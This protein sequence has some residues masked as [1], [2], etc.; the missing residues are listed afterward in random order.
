[1]ALARRILLALNP[2]RRRTRWPL[3]AAIALAITTLVLFPRLDLL[4]RDLQHWSR[5]DALIE[6]DAPGLAALE[7]RV[8]Q[9]LGVALPT[10]SP[11]DP[12]R[13]APAPTPQLNGPEVLRITQAVVEEAIPYAW[14]WDTWW[15]AD[16]VPR[17]HET[18]KAGREDCDGRAVVAASLLKRM[19]Y[20]A[21]LMSDMGHVWVWTP[22]GQTMNP[23]PLAG[24]AVFVVQD[25][26]GSRLNW[27]A[28][29]NWRSIIFDWGRNISYGI[30]VFPLWRELIL[31]LTAWTLVLGRNTRWPS[32]LTGLGLAI[33][34]WMLIRWTCGDFWNPSVAA[35]WAGLAF[36][37]AGFGLT[38]WP[39]RRVKP[40]TPHPTPPSTP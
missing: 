7:A 24:G 23:S 6:P 39:A 20:D 1:M 10:P 11:D 29:F 5:L 31:V 32:A 17:V 35:A 22:E 15:V 33:G 16:Y 3:K 40:A 19:G 14:D 21:R 28:V 18:L 13:A 26:Q 38:A 9:R 8:R 27:N 30:A 2:T 34:G 12:P 36:A 25:D 37:L 4:L